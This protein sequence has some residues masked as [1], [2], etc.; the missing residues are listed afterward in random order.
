MMKI[1]L[2][3][4]VTLPISVSKAL[5]KE[6]ESLLCGVSFQHSYANGAV[7]V[8]I[9]EKTSVRQADIW[10]RYT[11]SPK[12]RE[13]RRNHGDRDLSNYTR[14]F[15]CSIRKLI[16]L[17]SSFYNGESRFEVRTFYNRANDCFGSIS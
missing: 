3:K 13:R 11:I 12:D 5:C 1:M 10:R 14:T 15:P 2:A 6:D 9:I 16:S 17:V 8:R 7:N 4:A